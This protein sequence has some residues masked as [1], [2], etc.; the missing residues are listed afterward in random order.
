MTESLCSHA[1]L[2]QKLKNILFLYP[3]GSHQDQ[4]SSHWQ[5]G[6]RSDRDQNEIKRVQAGIRLAVQTGIRRVQTGIRLAVQTRFRPE[7][8]KFRLGSDSQFKPESDEFRLG[9]DLQFRPESDEFRLGSMAQSSPGSLWDTVDA[10]INVS[11]VGNP[12]LSLFFFF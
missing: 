10:K 3:R 1:V 5:F 11:S 6:P 8:D 12:D 4:T 7:S 2:I 9:S